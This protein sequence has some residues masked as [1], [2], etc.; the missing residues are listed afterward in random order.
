MGARVVSYELR[1]KFLPISQA[2]KVDIPS[3]MTAKAK[4]ILT[5]DRR[6][7]DFSG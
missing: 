1:F 4:T 3:K 7:V 6:Q 2:K 5:A